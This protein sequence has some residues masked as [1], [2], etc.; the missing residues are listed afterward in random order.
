M[1]RFS[2]LRNNVSRMVSLANRDLKLTAF[3][4]RL[5]KGFSCK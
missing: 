3:H 5:T 2:L 4:M 1:V